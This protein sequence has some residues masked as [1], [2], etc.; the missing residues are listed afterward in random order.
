MTGSMKPQG[1]P[2]A[3]LKWLLQS[4]PFDE[5]AWRR[6]SSIHLHVRVGNRPVRTGRED[7]IAE[8]R[9]LL[10]RVDRVGAGY[11]ECWQRRGSIFV[12][13]ELHVVGPVNS[14]LVIPC[15]LIART[16]KGSLQDLRFYLDPTPLR[17]DD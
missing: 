16:A 1:L 5:D 12:E 17:L 2:A 3:H 8:I 14:V 13:S 11:C 15:S 6:S 4:Q 7:A 9:H 10:A